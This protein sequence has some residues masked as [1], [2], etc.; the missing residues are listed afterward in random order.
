[1]GEGG[2]STHPQDGVFEPLRR[3]AVQGLGL[4]RHVLDG[5]AEGPDERPQR[6]YVGASKTRAE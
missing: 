2:P 5:G 3:R 1:M 6:H 4:R